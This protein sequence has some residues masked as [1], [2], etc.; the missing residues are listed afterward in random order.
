MR[1]FNFLSWFIPRYRNKW[2]FWYFVF[3]T[4]WGCGMWL[5]FHEISRLYWQ[6]HRRN[7]QLQNN[8]GLVALSTEIRLNIQE[9]SFVKRKKIVVTKWIR[10]KDTINSQIQIGKCSILLDYMFHWDFYVQKNFTFTV[11]NFNILWNTAF[12]FYFK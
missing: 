2:Y 6:Y 11:E 12:F 8:P 5:Y 1:S 4:L 3:H 9:T 7:L 10:E